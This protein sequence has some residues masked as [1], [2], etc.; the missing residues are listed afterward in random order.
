M[1]VNATNTTIILSSNK[2][3]FIENG[4]YYLGKVNIGFFGNDACIYGPG[5][6]PNDYKNKNMPVRKMIA[7]VCYSTNFFG[8]SKPRE[9]KVFMLKPNVDYY[10]HLEGTV[11]GG[12]EIPLD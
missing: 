11:M 3:V 1:S 8:M 2:D 9:F 4:E 7:T 10:S 6:N 5:S 12:K